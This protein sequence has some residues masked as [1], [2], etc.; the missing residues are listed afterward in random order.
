MARLEKKC[1]GI[2]RMSESVNSVAVYFTIHA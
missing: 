1:Y 2:P